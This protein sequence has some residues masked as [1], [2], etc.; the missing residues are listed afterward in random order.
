[1]WNLKQNPWKMHSNKPI[2]LEKSHKWKGKTHEN[3]DVLLN[4]IYKW[5]AFCPVCSRHIDN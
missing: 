1:M 5:N 3:F 4:S 2:K